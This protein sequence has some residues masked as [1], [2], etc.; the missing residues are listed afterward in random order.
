MQTADARAAGHTLVELLV[1][2]AVIG[3]LAAASVPVIG[4]VLRRDRSGHDEVVQ[5]LRRARATAIETGEVVSL[6]LSQDGT[7]WMMSSSGSDTLGRFK[8]HAGT[9]GGSPSP[10]VIRFS[11]W[12]G[13]DGGPI[14]IREAHRSV[15][16]LLDPWTA[17]VDVAE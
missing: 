14:I 1:V 9:I 17:R 13:A 2:I 12:G 11:P 7:L 3:M 8:R 16:L 5:L 15:V 6:T 10:A 4:S